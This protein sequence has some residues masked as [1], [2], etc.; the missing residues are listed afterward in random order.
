M[1]ATIG[2]AIMRRNHALF[3]GMT[4]GMTMRSLLIKDTTK[5]ERMA[6]IE[7]SVGG[8]A[9][10]CDGC[11]RNPKNVRPYIEGEMELRECNMAFRAH[12]IS[13]KEHPVKN[14]CGYM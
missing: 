6:I 5:E 7:E 12:Y 10:G 14:G 3:T 2:V 13:G 9:G 1:S 8:D 11:R 4:G